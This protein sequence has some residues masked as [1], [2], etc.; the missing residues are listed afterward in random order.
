MPCSVTCLRPSPTQAH[1]TVC[2][3]TFGSVTGFDRHRRHGVC[4]DP[5]ALGFAPD[6]RGVWRIPMAAVEVE[7][8]RAARLSPASTEPRT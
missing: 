5:L 8:R 1:C 3:L 6:D 7:R 2:H 4:L